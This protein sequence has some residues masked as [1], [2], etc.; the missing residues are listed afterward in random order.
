[1]RLRCRYAERQHLVPFIPEHIKRGASRPC[2]SNLDRGAPKHLRFTYEVSRLRLVLT[3]QAASEIADEVALSSLTSRLALLCLHFPRLRLI[4]SRSLHATA[5][6][7]LV[8]VKPPLGQP[9]AQ[10]NSE[11]HQRSCTASTL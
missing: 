1:M 2:S 3:M 4:W 7:F 6:I 8:R 11:Y 10:I 5:D 9:A